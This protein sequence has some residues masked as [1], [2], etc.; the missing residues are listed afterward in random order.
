M[1]QKLTA[2]LAVVMMFYYT[3][4]QCRRLPETL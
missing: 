3:Y 1:K 4:L 2:I